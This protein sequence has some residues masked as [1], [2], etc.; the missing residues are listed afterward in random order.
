MRHITQCLLFIPIAILSCLVLFPAPAMAQ[1]APLSFNSS[2]QF[3]WGD[4][5]LGQNQAILAQYLRFSFAPEG[6]PYSIWGYGRLWKD[7]GSPAVRDDDLEGRLYYLYLDY[8]LTPNISTRIGR[9]FTNLTAGTSIMDGISLDVHQIG[10]VGATVAV[11]R[12][13]VYTLDSE[14]SRSGNYFAGI[15]VHLDGIK[16]TQLGVSYVRRYDES[17]LSREELGMNFRYFFKS[18]SPYAE[19]KY[20]LISR[21]F[22]EATVGVDFFPTSNLMIKAEFFHSYPTF[23]TTDIYSVFAVDKFQEYLIRFEYALAQPVTLVAGYSRQTYDEGDNADVFTL[24]AKIYPTDNLSLYAAYDYREGFT[25]YNGFT[26]Q[27]KGRLSGFEANADYKFSKKLMFFAGLQYDSYNRPENITD[28]NFAQRY[29]I[30]G[31]WIATKQLSVTARI[32]ENS[33]ENF[34]HRALGRVALD[35][36]L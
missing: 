16:N 14:F 13:V 3:L 4:D 31:R 22:D 34:N 11:G 15:D 25:G 23:N 30:G 12:D 26:K 19:L 20:D 9:Q 6:K 7:F 17:D 36:K 32:E 1:S 33:N 27:V 24:G 28:T 21:V 5:L 2:T 8:A 18:L 35:W 29:W 10:P